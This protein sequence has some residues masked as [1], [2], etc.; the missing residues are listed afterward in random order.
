MRY[1]TVTKTKKRHRYKR[2][3]DLQKKKKIENKSPQGPQWAASGMSQKRVQKE[4]ERAE[5]R[6]KDVEVPARDPSSSLGLRLWSG[7]L[8]RDEKELVK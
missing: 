8:K 2:V 4:D 5:L 6:D 1:Q 7:T 3:N